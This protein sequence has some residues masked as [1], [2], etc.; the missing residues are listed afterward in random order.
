MND[1]AEDGLPDDGR[2]RPPDPRMIPPWQP[3]D[4]QPAADGSARSGP[5]HAGPEGPRPGSGPDPVDDIV[6]RPFLLTGGRTAPAQAG[7]R[8]ETLIQAGPHAATR[9]QRFEARQI[10]E[11]CRRPSSVAEVAAALRVPLGV[12]RVLVADLIADGSVVLVQREEVSVQ[13]ME[14]VLDR[15]RAL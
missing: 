2:A 4:L 14:R 12:A 15:V 13:L 6:I 5:R 7:L 1:Q 11:L 8:V 10:V 3:P 9:A